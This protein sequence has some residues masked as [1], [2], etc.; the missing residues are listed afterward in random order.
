MSEITVF[1]DDLPLVHRKCVRLIV[2]D[3]DGSILLLATRDPT[4][5]ELGEWWELPGGGIEEG[6]TLAQ[7][8]A[9][10]LWEETGISV[11]I[12]QIGHPLWSRTSTFKVHG[13]RH[14][15]SEEVMVVSIDQRQPELD[16]D[17]REGVEIEDYFDHRWWSV[18]DILR[19]TEKFYPGRIAKHLPEVLAGVRV[20]EPF[21]R[22][23]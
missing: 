17:N 11:A 9:R 3:A 5:P 6:E 10:E 7:A 22:W 14:V 18:A 15:Q 20:R 2:T 8:A 1:G 4:Y 23:S 16:T 12:E 19:S 21:E 13:T